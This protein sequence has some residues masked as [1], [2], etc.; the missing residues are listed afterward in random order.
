MTSS[1][2]PMQRLFFALWPPIELSRELHQLAGN[3]LRGGAGRRVAPEN[4]HLTL[5]FLGSVDASFRECAEQAGTALRVAPFS[6]ILGQVGHWPKSGVLWAGPREIPEPLLLLVRELNTGL[7]SCGYAAEKH[8]YTPH[9]TLARKARPGRERLS[10]ESRE[11]EINQFHLVQ[12]RTQ[13]EGARYEIVRTWPLSPE[14][15]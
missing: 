13:A 6:L 3:A 4:L 2:G 8:V 15:G 11:W 9:L 14:S 10:M 7:A 5:A 1:A 12:S